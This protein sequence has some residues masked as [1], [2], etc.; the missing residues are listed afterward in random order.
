MKKLS[1]V[2]VMLALTA[3]VFANGA[4][5]NVPAGGESGFGRGDG[6]L[7][8]VSGTLNT[9][10]A[11]VVLDSLEFGQF[12]AHFYK[13]LRLCFQQ[14][15]LPS[16]QNTGLPVLGDPVGCADKGESWIAG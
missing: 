16:G 4:R 9:T 8:T 3:V 15:W 14:P 1:I 2:L 7:V 10:D 11:E 5:E 12:I 13:E 6:E